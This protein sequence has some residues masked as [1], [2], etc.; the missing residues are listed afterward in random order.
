MFEHKF[1]TTSV[2]TYV[3]VDLYMNDLCSCESPTQ[4]DNDFVLTI[5]KYIKRFPREFQEF[6]SH[7]LTLSYSMIHKPEFMIAQRENENQ[8]MQNINDILFQRTLS[9]KEWCRLK[10]K[11]NCLQK[12]IKHLN[13]SQSLVNYCTFDIFKPNYALETIKQVS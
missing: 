8:G 2:G 6:I 1:F 10:I 7:R 12:D 4:R 13:L 5:L 9:L 11:D 3:L